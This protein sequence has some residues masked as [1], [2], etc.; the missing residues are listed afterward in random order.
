MYLVQQRVALALVELL[1]SLGELLFPP[2]ER[3]ASELRGPEQLPHHHA[4]G[5]EGAS[6]RPV[7]SV[8]AYGQHTEVRSGH[9]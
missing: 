2:G 8:Q 5:G 1:L 3:L 4:G 9:S 6:E 7:G